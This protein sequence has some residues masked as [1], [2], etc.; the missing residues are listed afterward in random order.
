MKIKY[1][2]LT[3][4]A[5]TAFACDS[6]LDQEPTTSWDSETFY[7]TSSEAELGLVGI[8]NY[9]GQDESYGS[10]LAADFQAGTDE[11]SYSRNYNESWSVSLYQ[12][13]SSTTEIEDCWYNLYR[14]IDAA[15]KFIEKVSISTAIDSTTKTTMLGEAHFLRAQYYFDLVRWFG[16]VPLRLST[17]TQISDN[18]KAVA[19]TEEVYASIISDL[20]LAINQCMSPEEVAASNLNGRVN[21]VAARGILARVYLTMAGLP[22]LQTEYYQEALAQC[23]TVVDYGYY[24]MNSNYESTFRNYITDVF[25]DK[26]TLL[27]VS[28]D[29]LQDQGLYEHGRIGN[30]NGVQFTYGGEGYPYA[31]AFMQLSLKLK[32]AYEYDDKRYD[33]NCVDYKFDNTT[34]DL[35]RITNELTWWPGKFR[36]YEPSDY[37]DLD[38]VRENESYIVL[39][40]SSSPSKNF[41][42]INFPLLRMADIWLMRAEAENEINGASAAAFTYLNK[43]RQR[44]GLS[45]LNE[46]NYSSQDLLRKEIQDE[47]FRELCFEGVRH[48]DLVRWGLLETALEEL[49]TMIET[50]N[51]YSDYFTYLLRQGENFNSSKHLTLPYPNQ[52]VLLNDSLEQKENW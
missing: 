31:Y 21:K 43:V 23:D 12:H 9:L 4:L 13:T 51:S 1:I 32:N 28:F 6:I 8:Y 29:Y 7:E 38:T 14:G 44:A 22:L 2:L 26:A 34:L 27:E 17:T 11:A 30:V 20:K 5:I 25:D 50:S 48:H 35:A 19:S 24:E 39:E 33:W 46:A 52:E 10:Y 16:P 18:N 47:R 45:D 37:S 36:R 41:T 49:N 15:N 40:S 3:T 42:G